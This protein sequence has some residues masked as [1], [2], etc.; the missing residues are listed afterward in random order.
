MQS[1][2]SLVLGFSSTFIT[3]TFP[4]PECLGCHSAALPAA[5]E[6]A[7]QEER[8]PQRRQVRDHRHRQSG[9]HHQ[10]PHCGC[11]NSCQVKHLSSV[12]VF[13]CV[14][15]CVCVCVRVRVRV[16][17]VCVSVCLCVKLNDNVIIMQ[18]KYC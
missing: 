13:V 11:R 16:C 15:V 5:P 14:C 2:N 9:C 6:G 1:K 10:S 8:Q 7:D 12:C 17:G 4:S 18:Y 3:L